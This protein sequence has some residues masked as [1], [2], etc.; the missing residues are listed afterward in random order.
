MRHHVSTIAS[1][2]KLA[3]DVGLRDGCLT[4]ASY[5]AGAR[6]EYD[7]VRQ[8]VGLSDLSH[9]AKLRVVGDLALDLLNHVVL[10]DLAR[11]PINQM[12]VTPLVDDDGKPCDLYAVTGKA[13]CGDHEPL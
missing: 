5:A 12:Q 8:R 7:C 6:A 4:A 3:H 9:Y 11:L 10:S 13:K 1:H 2:L